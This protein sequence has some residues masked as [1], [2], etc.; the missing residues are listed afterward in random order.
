MEDITSG[1]AADKNFGGGESDNQTFEDNLHTASIRAL[2]E[3][4]ETAMDLK[5]FGSAM[6]VFQRRL[7]YVVWRS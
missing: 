5:Q 2:L 6:G 4:G 3:L 7:R 1:V